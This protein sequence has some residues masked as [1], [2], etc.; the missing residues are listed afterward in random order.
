MSTKAERANWPVRKGRL[1]EEEEFPDYSHLTPDECMELV[2]E[3]SRN[4][5]AFMGHTDADRRLQRHVL[6]I[7]RR[8][9]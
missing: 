4:A 9:R 2:C 1:G 6:R 7:V 3:L 8:G 5:W